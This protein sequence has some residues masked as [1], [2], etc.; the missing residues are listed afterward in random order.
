[1]QEAP[2]GLDSDPDFRGDDKTAT[3]AADCAVEHG[4]GQ[5]KRELLQRRVRFPK[6]RPADLPRVSAKS[7]AA[8]AVRPLQFGRCSSA[9]AVRPLQF[10]RCSSAVAVRPLQFGRCSSPYPR[11]SEASLSP[12]TAEASRP[13]LLY[14]RAQPPR[15]RPYVG[16][17]RPPTPTA[18]R[19]APSPQPSPTRQA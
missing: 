14:K 12:P 18:H 6:V 16:P 7:A 3:A 5:Q 10:G 8:V 2:A 15:A 13:P 9:V 19:T 4:F 17:A 11:K 1:M